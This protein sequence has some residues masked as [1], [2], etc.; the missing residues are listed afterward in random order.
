MKNKRKFVVLISAN[1]EWQAVKEILA[2][3]AIHSTPLG[4]WF[5]LAL[6]TGTLDTVAH[7]FHGGWGKIS[8]AATAQYVIDHFHPDLLINLGTCGGFKGRIER[9][10]IILVTKTIVYDILE[11][12]SDPDEAIAHYSTDLDLSWLPDDGPRSTVRG[13]LVSADRD[14]LRED[15]PM[16]AEKYGAIA[17]DWESGAIA[18][19]AQ[20][21]EI[22]CLILRGV[23]DL[24]SEEGGE[25]Y[26]NIELFHE[27]TRTIMKR[28]IEQLP[29][30]LEKFQQKDLSRG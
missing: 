22:K 23:T 1:A 10:T 27:N 29:D 30:W 8:A 13:P 12:M 17:A 9:G 7:F 5:D 20:K 2:P 4:E 16:L 15:I 24:V 21:N 6:D 11:Q 3:S 26:G 25:A 19:V 28:L 18:W 14:L